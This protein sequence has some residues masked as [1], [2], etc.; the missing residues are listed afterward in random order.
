ML[1]RRSLSAEA[2]V[3]PERFDQLVNSS[4]PC[5]EVFQ[6]LP[7]ARITRVWYCWFAGEHST[8]V[9]NEL[10]HCNRDTELPILICGFTITPIWG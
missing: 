1:V 4:A 3:F 7:I 5:V 10:S 8:H 2:V 6:L 9:S